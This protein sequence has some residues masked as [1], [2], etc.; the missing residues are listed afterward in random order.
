MEIIRMVVNEKNALSTRYNKKL[1][2]CGQGQTVLRFL[3]DHSDL[4]PTELDMAVANQCLINNLQQKIVF[5]K[6][7]FP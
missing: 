4:N 1:I 5:L 2:L 3:S 6:K 7:C